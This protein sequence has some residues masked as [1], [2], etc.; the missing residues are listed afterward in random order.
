MFKWLSNIISRMKKAFS[1]GVCNH[2][3]KPVRVINYMYYRDNRY[4]YEAQCAK[5]GITCNHPDLV[6]TGCWSG[7]DGKPRHMMMCKC[8]GMKDISYTSGRAKYLC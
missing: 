1:R 4:H 6:D 2:D 3:W 7:H 5:C 8:C